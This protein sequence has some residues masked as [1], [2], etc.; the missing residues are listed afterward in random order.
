[1]SEDEFIL[2]SDSDVSVVSV[3]HS[4]SS[5][6]SVI[7]S[8]PVKSTNARS[9]TSFL[10]AAEQRA[11]DKKAEKKDKEEMYNFLREDV[12]KDVG[13]PIDYLTLLMRSRKTA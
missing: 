10:T 11:A 4:S 5:A 2:P 12:L 13:W 9:K 6:S 3:P 1:V 7:A 8:S